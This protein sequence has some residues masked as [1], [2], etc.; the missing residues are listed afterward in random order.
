MPE[1]LTTGCLLTCS[2]GLAPSVFVAEELPGKPVIEGGFVTA[3][4]AEIIPEDNV[5]SFAMCSSMEN[6]EVAAATAAAEGVLTPMPCVPVIVDPWEPPSELVSYDGL[7]L[8]TV[9]S[10]C[11][12]AW[13]G[14][15]AVDAPMEFICATQG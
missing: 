10:K 8:A 7:P 11:L 13:G 14:E 12:C 9:E 6:P 4:V 1:F 3:T 5:P 2:F 15:I